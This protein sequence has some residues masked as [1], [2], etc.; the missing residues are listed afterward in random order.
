MDLLKKTTWLCVAAPVGVL[1]LTLT[2]CGSSG[3]KSHTSTSP[4][5]KPHSRFSGTHKNGTRGASAAAK[6]VLKPGQSASR[7]FKEDT[8]VK[9]FYSITARRID[10]GT[11]AE[12][13]ALVSDP[14]DAKGKVPATGY[15]TYRHLSGAAV[16]EWP[17]VGDY[18]D[19]YADGQRGAKVIGGDAPKGCVD[20]DAVKNWKD[21][22]SYSLCNTFLIPADTKRL[23]IAWTEIGGK[24]FVWK[25]PSRH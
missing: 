19:V 14:A 4:K 6:A 1:A 24:P 20:P 10:I 18:A 9:P 11:A 22:Q 15:V 8:G 12:A 21:G 5:H 16:K 7:A 25:F 23:E 3:K 13:K 17:R 2:A